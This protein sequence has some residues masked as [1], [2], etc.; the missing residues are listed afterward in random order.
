MSNTYQVIYNGTDT[1]TWVGIKPENLLDGTGLATS[2]RDNKWYSREFD[3]DNNPVSDWIEIH[4]GTDNQIMG[5]GFG[6]CIHSPGVGPEVGVWIY[7]GST[8]GPSVAHQ[9]GHDA[10]SQ[11][12]LTWCVI[13]CVRSTDAMISA[14]GDVED[15]PGEFVFLSTDDMIDNTNDRTNDIDIS[16]PYTIT[17]MMARIFTGHIPCLSLQSINSVKL[18]SDVFIQNKNTKA[19]SWVHISNYPFSPLLL[20]HD[21]LVKGLDNQE[22]VKAENYTDHRYDTVDGHDV[23]DL[24]SDDGRFI[25]VKG[26][27][28][29]TS[30]SNDKEE[31]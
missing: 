23:V 27:W 18:P 25:M 1:S 31:Q 20:T 16:T 29:K 17:P 5:H 10:S 13:G 21:H 2:P 3:S 4:A 7:F 24:V 12:L 26:V 30:K 28:V 14:V 15:R 22:P 9:T 11:V 19:H 6:G 8:G